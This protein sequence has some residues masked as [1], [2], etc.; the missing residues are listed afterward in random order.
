MLYR[1][2]VDKAI[3]TL[4]DQKVKMNR[5]TLCRKV[6]SISKF[7]PIEDGPPSNKK[8]TLSSDKKV[9]EENSPP[10]ENATTS[11]VRDIP[12]CI[13]VSNNGSP[14]STF[15]LRDTW[16]QNNRLGNLAGPKARPWKR[17]GRRK[18]I[19]KRARTASRLNIR[20]SW[21]LPNL[22]R[23]NC[24][25]VGLLSSSLQRRR[26]STLSVPSVHVE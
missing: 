24:Q 11:S 16:K 22:L 14:F 1:K 8:T 7:A 12:A 13:V 15:T 23:T 6:A 26:S 20:T 5:N 3:A 18:Q 17:K 4:A 9:L 19:T 21:P 25:K 10:N 2:A